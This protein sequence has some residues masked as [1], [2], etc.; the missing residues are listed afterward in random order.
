VGP[1]IPADWGEKRKKSGKKDPIRGPKSYTPQA[2]RPPKG[3]TSRTGIDQGFK[4]ATARRQGPGG[5]RY[6]VSGEGRLETPPPQQIVTG[7]GGQQKAHLTQENTEKMVQ[8][9]PRM[10][11]KVPGNSV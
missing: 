11:L 9:H 3:T 7:G 4:D 10:L 5:A 6:A 8:L 1:P 2:K